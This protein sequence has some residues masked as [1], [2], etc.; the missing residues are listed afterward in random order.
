MYS[1]IK[2]VGSKIKFINISSFP[3]KYVAIMAIVTFAFFV[4]GEEAKVYINNYRYTFNVN[5]QFDIA[6]HYINELKK[7]G[8]SNVKFDPDFRK[9][10]I[11]VTYIGSG[12]GFTSS[13]DTGAGNAFWD[14]T[15][16]GKVAKCKLL[17][18]HAAIKTEDNCYN[19]QVQAIIYGPRNALCFFY[20]F[21]VKMLKDK[22]QTYYAIIPESIISNQ[23]A[24]TFIFSS[25]NKE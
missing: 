13:W 12:D 23:K 15:Y 10:E 16:D 2:N 9:Y 17:C 7:T 20:Q 5:Y 21:S 24:A 8:I 1:E 14:L 11:N 18:S 6:N 25:Q 22:G 19:L 3:I 4:E